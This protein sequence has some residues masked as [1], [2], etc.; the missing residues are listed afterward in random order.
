MRA[1]NVTDTAFIGLDVITAPT[2]IAT[3]QRA[4]MT[5][6]TNW[7]FCIYFCY[8]I[9]TLN[10]WFYASARFKDLFLKPLSGMA[11]SFCRLFFWAFM[12]HL[13]LWAFFY[14]THQQGKRDWEK[15]WTTKMLGTAKP[16]GVIFFGT[17]GEDRNSF[18]SIHRNKFDVQKQRLSDVDMK[19]AQRGGKNKEKSRTE[20]KEDII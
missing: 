11:F 19:K 13:S 3:A 20:I 2:N 16:S 5:E 17:K 12:P 10:F 14:G 6:K 8:L 9:C 15:F 18:V 7:M 4:M 1:N